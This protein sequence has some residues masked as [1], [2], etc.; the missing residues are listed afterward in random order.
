MFEFTRRRRFRG[1]VGV[2]VGVWILVLDSLTCPFLHGN[3]SGTNLEVEV[4]GTWMSR[5]GS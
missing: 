1:S 3:Y 5:D 2:E 4:N